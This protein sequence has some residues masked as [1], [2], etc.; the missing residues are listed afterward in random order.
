MRRTHELVQRSPA[1]GICD[2]MQV[3]MC[4]RL[5]LLLLGSPV[6]KLATPETSGRLS[7][8]IQRLDFWDRLGN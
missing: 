5:V 4:R 7:T 1:A 6:P 3:H 2:K 8:S